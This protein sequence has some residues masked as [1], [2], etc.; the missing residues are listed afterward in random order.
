[1]EAQLSQEKILALAH[2]RCGEQKITVHVVVLQGGSTLLVHNTA[3]QLPFKEVRF[4]RDIKPEKPEGWGIVTGSVKPF[5]TP[6]KA[7]SRELIEET[8]P[9]SQRGFRGFAADEV[10]IEPVPI[11]GTR[12][13][14][15]CIE[16]TFRAHIDAHCTTPE[17]W[18]VND[19]AAGV[20]R[21][22]WLQ[23]PDQI[24]KHRGQHQFRGLMVYGNHVRI[25]KQSAET[26]PPSA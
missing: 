18:D 6:L 16:L 2:A 19:S 22:A 24:H 8:K 20:I 7:A 15:G 11:F 3:K 9:M 14:N 23:R 26:N 10:H 5:E 4:G 1:M 12:K 17:S 21:A 25:I 13:D